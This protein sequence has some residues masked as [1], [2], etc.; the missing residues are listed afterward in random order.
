[1]DQAAN[2]SEVLAWSFILKSVL[3]TANSYDVSPDNNNNYYVLCF[4][5]GH[6]LT[7]KNPLE[8]SGFLFFPVRLIGAKLAPPKTFKNLLTPD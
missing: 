3:R 2:L 8:F 5:S 4:I 7:H 1:M 6:E